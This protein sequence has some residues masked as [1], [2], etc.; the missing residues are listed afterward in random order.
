MSLTEECLKK[1]YEE[2][3]KLFRQKSEIEQKI[4]DATDTIIDLKIELAEK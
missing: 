2:I 1:K 3:F 4:F